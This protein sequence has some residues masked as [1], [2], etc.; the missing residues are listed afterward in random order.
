MLRTSEARRL[1]ARVLVVSLAGGLACRRAPPA[2]ASPPPPPRPVLGE[3]VV[4]D[5]TPPEDAPAHLDVEALS[6]GLRSRLL[7]TKLFVEAGDA[8][9]EPGGASAKRPV[10]RARAQVAVEGV[11]V[12][13]KGLA[14]AH[15]LLQLETRPSTA[16][17][18]IAERF[19]A[20]GELPYDVPP[21][22]KRKH[23][24]APDQ[25]ALYEGLILRIAGDLLE[26]FAGRSQLATATPEALRD[27]LRGDGGEVRLEALRLIGTRHVAS[28]A[29]AV[30]PF[31]DDP[32][33]PTRDAALGA[34]IALGDRRAVTSLTRSRS[35]RDRREMRKIIEALGQLGGEEADQYLSFVASTHDDEEIRDSAAAARARL[36]RA[37]AD[38]GHP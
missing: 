3:V 11:E 28:A 16:P 24:P 2:V 21:T 19:D 38:A 8:G 1:L 25:R 15:L 30:L 33:E 32:D 22:P 29:D 34:L 20:G 31:L 23:A 35:L 14:R 4:R 5:L 9:A 12:H 26:G 18:A 27:S 6:R 17:G 37:A 36:A 10:T 13:D 7:A